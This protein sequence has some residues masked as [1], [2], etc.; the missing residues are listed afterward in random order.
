VKHRRRKEQKIDP[1]DYANI[2]E[3]IDLREIYLA[4]SQVNV[5]R[6]K[7][8]EG[9]ELSVQLKDTASF[10]QEEDRAVVTQKYQLLLFTPENE[11]DHVLKITCVFLLTFVTKTP[12]TKEFFSVFKELT[13][14]LNSWPFFREFVQNMTQRM[15]MPPLTLPLI[16]RF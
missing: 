15:S 7:I 9:K 14:P 1:K 16:K 2:I 6:D 11:K 4:S 5:S 12:F 8:L 10:T 13:L 3:G